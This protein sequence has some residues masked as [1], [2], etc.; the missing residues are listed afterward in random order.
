ME[1][2]K[3]QG[4]FGLF[5]WGKSYSIVIPPKIMAG[6][7]H[8][9]GHAKQ[10]VQWFH[11]VEKVVHG[12]RVEY[13]LDHLLIPP[14]YVSDKEVETDTNQQ[15]E[16]WNYLVKEFGGEQEA[17]EIM[18][19]SGV[20][21][22]SHVN[23]APTPSPEDN[24]QWERQ[25]KSAFNSNLTTPQI[26]IIFN[27]KGIVYTRVYDPDEGVAFK[28]VPIHEV[29][30]WDFSKIDALM[31]IHLRKKPEVV[32][33]ATKPTTAKPRGHSS[34]Y[35]VWGIQSSRPATGFSVGKKATLSPQDIDTLENLLDRYQDD[36]SSPSAK[37]FEPI[38]RFLER[39]LDTHD[40]VAIATMIEDAEALDFHNTFNLAHGAYRWTPKGSIKDYLDR[41]KNAVYVADQQVAID[42]IETAMQ[43]NNAK[44]SVLAK[45]YLEDFVEL[46]RELLAEEETPS[47]EVTN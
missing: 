33:Q 44:S 13:H 20:W 28:N 37:G 34:P 46:A 36:K 9:V 3:N 30:A 19:R 2:L 21:C 17:S 22:H 12:K 15:I 24:R 18:S 5:S 1:Q 40:W 41:A 39:Y 31:K 16:Y 25:L 38:Y 7:R 26:M 4:E 35:G 6:I 29:P 42:A 47:S 11:T 23:M 32:I 10:E 8:I 14:Q 45:Q 27:K 43:L